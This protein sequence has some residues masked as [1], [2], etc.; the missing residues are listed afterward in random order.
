[1]APLAKDKTQSA[2]SFCVASEGVSE[3][4][5]Y[6]TLGRMGG[7]FQGRTN[8]CGLF[9]ISAGLGSLISSLIHQADWSLQFYGVKKGLFNKSQDEGRYD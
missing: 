7:S 4:K 6:G 2:H 5:R 1:M 9:Q 3:R 8:V